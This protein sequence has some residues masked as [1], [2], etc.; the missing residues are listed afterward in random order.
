MEPAFKLFAMGAVYVV[1]GLA[2]FA[3]RDLDGAG[4]FMIA[5]GVV[6]VATGIWCVVRGGNVPHPPAVLP[7]LPSPAPA[8]GCCPKCGGASSRPMTAIETTAYYGYDRFVLARPRTC[9]GCGSGFEVQP[10]RAGCYLMVACTAVAGLAGVALIG[11]GPLLVWVRAHNAELDRTEWAEAVLG[12]VIITGG[13]GWWVY[14][15]WLFGRRYWWLLDRGRTRR[16][17]RRRVA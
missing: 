3:I 5:I 4:W 2:S 7:D 12:G 17:T 6:A 11:G 8:G 1:A 10:S 9:L 15:C 14:R 16:Y 13:G